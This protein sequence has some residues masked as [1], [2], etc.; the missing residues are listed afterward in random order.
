MADDGTTELVA[1][2]A[3]EQD[4]LVALLETIEPDDWFRPTPAWSWDV[5]DTV[6]HLADT[7]ELA[8]DTCIDG[9]RALAKVAATCA[10]SEDLTLQGVL[11]GRRL[12]GSDVLHWWKDAQLREREV[13]SELDPAMRVPWGLGMRPPSFVT[14]R[15]MECWAHSL[16]VHT[17]MD[18]EIVDTDRLRHVAWIGFRALPYA[19]SVAGV[20]P[21][22]E[23]IRVELTLP[24]GA[25]WTFGPEDTRN[26]ITGPASE[27]CRVF[28]QR[29]RTED[30]TELVA[31]GDA[32][33]LALRVARSFL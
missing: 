20:A 14:A 16:D 31:E 27:F 24:S 26:R 1:D 17:A 13:L 8:V 33:A 15:L 18:R 32:A 2:L 21:P 11:H 30:A 10:S 6:A 23:P 3:A 25:T 12:T 29:M 5:R 28:V 4:V 19:C 7:D 9:P 22:E